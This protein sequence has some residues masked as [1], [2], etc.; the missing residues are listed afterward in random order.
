MKW[1]QLEAQR[2]E[3]VLA[4]GYMSSET[5]GEEDS[6]GGRHR[7]VRQVRPL[8]WESAS[9]R[10]LKDQL[11]RCYKDNIQTAL[12]RKQSAEVQQ[13]FLPPSTRCPPKDAPAWCLA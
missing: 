3:E 7:Q 8:L 12:Q 1:S 4:T 6:V 13:G 5:D 2:C 11:D 10:S 9:L